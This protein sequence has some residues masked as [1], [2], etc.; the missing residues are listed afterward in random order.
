M[1]VAVVNVDAERRRQ[2]SDLVLGVNEGGEALWRRR[3]L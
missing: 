2:R 3:G 1:V